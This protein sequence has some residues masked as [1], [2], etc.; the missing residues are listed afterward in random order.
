MS[1]PGNAGAQISTSERLAHAVTHPAWH[2]FDEIPVEVLNDPETIFLNLSGG[3]QQI[4]DEIRRAGM[5]AVEEGY[6]KIQPVPEFNQAVADKFR[7][8]FNVDVDPKTEVISCNGAGDGLLAALSVLLN[9]GDEVITFDPGYTLSYLIPAYLSAT[10]RT[11]PLSG[12][13]GWSADADTMEAHLD[14]LLTPRTRAFIIVNPDNPTG[15]VFRRDFLERLGK[16]LCRHGIPVVE[17]QVY[18]KV[19]YPP[20]QFV[21]MVTIP[22]MRDLTVCVSSFAKSYLCAGMKVGYIAAPSEIIRALRH[23]YMLSSFTPNTAALRTGI[24]ILRGPQDFLNRWIGDWDEMRQKT[25]AALNSIPGVAC[26]LPEAGTYC[27]ADISGLGSGEHIAKL[28]MDRARVLVTPGNY[29]GPS[30]DKYIRVCYG[31]SRPD[32]V[33]QGLERVVDTL[34]VLKSGN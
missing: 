31:R 34:K 27:L 2:G 21:S 12:S 22:E 4:P 29:Y 13:G 7:N 8:D 1:E 15:H 24:D 10:V 26:K 25:T 28:L 14:R 17:D 33:E 30:G 19:V 5:N 23:Y 6:L 9:P 3:W 11:V 18:E 16:R 20:H 32:R